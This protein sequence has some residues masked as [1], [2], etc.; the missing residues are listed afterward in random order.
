M[1]KNRFGKGRHRKFQDDWE[2][3]KEPVLEGVTFYAKYLGMCL[4]DLPNDEAHTTDAVKR[5]LHNAKYSNKMLFKK[6]SLTV[7]PKAIIQTNLERAEDVQEV[8]IHRVSYCAADK[9][10]DNKVFAYI[11]NNSINEA[12]ECHAYLC[13]KRKIA[14]ALT[15]T[16]AQ[17]F[18]IAFELWEDHDEGN[19]SDDSKDPLPASPHQKSAPQSIP[20]SI[21]GRDQASWSSGTSPTLPP[22]LDPPPSSSRRV[23][24]VQAEINPISASA[25]CTV[26]VIPPRRHSG[27]PC[28]SPPLVNGIGQHDSGVDSSV[29]SK[30]LDA[31]A[32]LLDKWH[33]GDDVDL[34]ESFAKLAE[35]RSN[36]QLLDINVRRTQFDADIIVH[37]Q[38]NQTE[39]D[40][41]LTSRSSE[42]FLLDL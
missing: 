31:T 10:S 25:P 6:V 38:G 14:E 7:T 39:R 29:D 41:L 30:E 32:K 27:K 26:P 42:N 20:T 28:F 36:P 17:A 5:I 21:N 3:S 33:I 2:R 37:Y 34:D 11:A 40:Q 4:V 8:S 22:S 35:S 19:V 12:L 23:L 1:M 15:L 9:T 24:T 18:N 13:S 16:V